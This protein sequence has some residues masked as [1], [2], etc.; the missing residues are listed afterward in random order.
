M[1]KTIGMA[2]RTTMG[3]L[4]YTLSTIT[5]RVVGI[6][7]HLVL[8]WILGSEDF[9][10]IG[11]AYAITSL[12][13]VIQAA[14]LREVL[15]RRRRKIRLWAKVA[16][17]ISLGF[18]ALAFLFCLIAGYA[19]AQWYQTPRLFGLI[20]IISCM[21]PIEALVEVPRVRIE[22]NLGFRALAVLLTTRT[23][24]AAFATVLLAACGFGAFS[25]AIPM[26]FAALIQLVMISRIC[27]LQ[28]SWPRRIGRFRILFK[29]SMAVVVGN[30]AVLWT[31]FADYLILGLFV[32]KS[33]IGNYYF[34]YNISVQP[35]RLLTSNLAATLLA[36]L[37]QLADDPNRQLAGFRRA[38]SAVAYVGIP[39]CLLQAMVARPLLAVLFQGKWDDAALLIEIMSCGMAFRVVSPPSISLIKI[40]GRFRTF[41]KLSLVNGLVFLG[42][43]VLGAWSR[44]VARNSVGD[45]RLFND[46]RP[47][48]ICTL[49]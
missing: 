39:L 31:G 18:S 34:A 42:L 38:V 45:F 3:T 37:N 46:C 19:L 44:G 23:T 41:F 16:V 35:I 10:E 9:G 4:W 30:F 26:P 20:A 43:V 2:A 28:F 1:N 32:A 33:A 11:L 13:R 22:N 17:W 24:C 36:T 8:A 25:Y 47:A 48:Q 12:G 49:H 5:N 14:G 40:Q 29:S 7:A 27:P 21:F 15:I 6:V